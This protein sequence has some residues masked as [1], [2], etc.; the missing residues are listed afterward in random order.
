[1]RTNPPA[2]AS[3]GCAAAQRRGT[4]SAS[5]PPTARSSAPA[6]HAATAYRQ[7]S[8]A[9]FAT[10]RAVTGIPALA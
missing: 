7:I 9:R 6:A 1:M 5:S 4:P 3:D 8:T 2:S 10:W